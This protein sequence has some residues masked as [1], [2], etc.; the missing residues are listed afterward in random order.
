MALFVIGIHPECGCVRSYMPIPTRDG[1]YPISNAIE[2]WKELLLYWTSYNL[3]IQIVSAEA[4]DQRY[5]NDNASCVSH[6][7][8][9]NRGFVMPIGVRRSVT[10]EEITKIDELVNAILVIRTFEGL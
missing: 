3:T 5:I 6:T 7:P 9:P 1:E 4:K 2:D 10:D 8:F